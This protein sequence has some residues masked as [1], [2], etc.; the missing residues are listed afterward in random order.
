M[1]R[2]YVQS[3]RTNR[4]TN[5]KTNRRLVDHETTARQSDPDQDL[6]PNARMLNAL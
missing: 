1:Q 6:N 2:V 4:K 5:R 3:C